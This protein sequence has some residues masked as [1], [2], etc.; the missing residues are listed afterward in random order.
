MTR[1]GYSIVFDCINLGNNL[2]QYTQYHSTVQKFGVCKI[3][4]KK[5]SEKYNFSDLFKFDLSEYA[6]LLNTQF[7]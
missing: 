1:L 5:L 4:K 7:V 3:K 2:V 6:Y